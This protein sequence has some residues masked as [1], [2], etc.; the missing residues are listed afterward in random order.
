VA[1]YR[2]AAGIPFDAR[3]AS[4]RLPRAVIFDMDGLMLDTERIAPRCWS[5]AALSIG[6]EFDTALLPSMIGRNSR[7]S[8]QLVIERYGADYPVDAL[9]RE[10]R[11]RF[12]AIVLCEGIAVKPGLHAL[13]DWLESIH[14]PRVVATS[15]R[16]ERAQAHLERCELLSRF[17]ALVGGDEVA[18]GKP[19]PDIFRLAAAR[20][21]VAPAGC[22]VLEDSE[23]GVRGALAAGMI[24]IMVPDMLAPSKDLL[25]CMPLVLASLADARRTAARRANPGRSITACH[26][27]DHDRSPHRDPRREEPAADP[28]RMLRAPYEVE[29]SD[30]TFYNL[31]ATG[32]RVVPSRILSCAR[33]PILFGFA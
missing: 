5:E 32:E 18:E 8:R 19:A 10:S 15:T 31:P 9:M 33:M 2:C 7:D 4:T 26:N 20:L 27:H 17:H 16:R 14:I 23:P 1:G 6:V 12:D 3:S 13:L 22:I 29:T 25:A 11:S 21:E 24:P 28:A 30:D